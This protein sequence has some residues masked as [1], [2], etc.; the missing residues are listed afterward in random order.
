MKN[1]RFA[2]FRQYEQTR[3][4]ASSAIMGLLAGT[5][6][7]AHMLQLTEGTDRLLPE[8]FPKI[9]HI[10]RL[11][12]KIEAARKVLAAGDI[13][14]GAMAVPYVLGIHEDYLRTCLTLLER[15]KISLAKPADD[16]TLVNQHE[17]IQSATGQSF[18]PTSLQQL[19]TLR[20]MRNCAVHSG[21]RVN[22]A[23]ARKL[24]VW[25]HQTE[26]GWVNLTG[27]SPRTLKAGDSITFSHGET[28]IGLLREFCDSG[29]A[30]CK[31]TRLR[32]RASRR[33][34]TSGV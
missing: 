8:I 1:V 23:L 3:T 29:Y 17:E 5:Q 20:L 25:T 11:N 13:H 28:L 19:H 16:L 32:R 10:G 33:G 24:S 18:R 4:E 26:A 7:A 31:M 34:R 27:R 30:G 22:G 21:G 2:A 15:A 9:P 12:L 6:M 14:L